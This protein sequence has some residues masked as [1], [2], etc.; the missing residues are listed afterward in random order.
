MSRFRC[1]ASDSGAVAIFV[2]LIMLPVLLGTVA[3]CVDVSRWFAVLERLQRAADASALAAAPLWNVNRAAARAA[4]QDAAARNGYP[5][6]VN[7]VLE[8]G[9]GSVPEHVRVRIT[10]RVTNVWGGAIGQSQR[11]LSRQADA[12]YAPPLGLGSTCNLF[13]NE[14]EPASGDGSDLADASG[15]VLSS[16]C[17]FGRQPHFWATIAGP[18]TAKET[19]DR[20]ATRWCA[21]YASGCV[22]GRNIDYYDGDGQPWY[23]YR[24]SVRS[25]VASMSVQIF[26]PA[27]VD[28]GD[29]CERLEH[30]SATDSHW[31][32]ADQANRYVTDA[33]T[34]YAFGSA[35]TVPSNGGEFCTGDSVPI[36]SAGK[37]LAVTSFAL[38]S[39]TSSGNPWRAP[40]LAN[41][42]RQFAGWSLTPSKLTSAL[43]STAA[44]DQQLQRVFRQWITLC[45]ITA[46]EVGD[47]LL[48]VRTNIGFGTATPARMA[49]PSE[50]GNLLGVGQ[51][52]FAIRVS[53]PG[54]Q[55][56]VVVSALERMPLFT[57]ASGAHTTFLL[58]RVPT[59][60]A[61][62][63]LRVEFFDLGDAQA[64][65]QVLVRPPAGARGL[66]ALSCW[67]LGDVRGS[68]S[69]PLA[70]PTCSLEGVSVNSGF[71]GVTQAM[72]I[73]I[74][75]DYACADDVP[76]DCWFTVDINYPTAARDTTTWTAVLQGDPV[77]LVR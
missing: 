19:G 65:V 11:L 44:N 27:L 73:S 68:P 12:T 33:T 43:T 40:V 26:D 77:R 14:P 16:Q 28:V 63:S 7:T 4:A 10:S 6:D 53:S 59:F 54:A 62:S 71:N 64:P 67:A 72:E 75:R 30:R 57:N 24:I 56:S 48:Q 25:P 22:Q 45:T 20:F 61:G 35:G 49:D 38:H 23:F 3:L 74:P 52:R 70:L 69:A 34:R 21:S 32:G 18:D 15:S 55:A 36:E 46:P 58:A 2:A 8:V 51:N 13:G 5:A 1:R 60:A 47:Y 31:P 39:P 41:C 50:D 66:G 76:T 17:P 29:Q 37:A 42:V 9:E